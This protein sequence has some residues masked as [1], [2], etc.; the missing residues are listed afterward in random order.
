MLPPISESLSGGVAAA[1][2][3]EHRTEGDTESGFMLLNKSLE[4]TVL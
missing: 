4:V 3:S 2:L 1:V